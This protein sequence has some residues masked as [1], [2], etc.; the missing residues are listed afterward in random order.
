LPGGKVPGV[1]SG[2]VLPVFEFGLVGLG[3]VFVGPV[4]GFVAFGFVGFGFGVLMP[5]EPDPTTT[6]KAFPAMSGF[7]P[8]PAMN[9]LPAAEL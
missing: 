8:L 1:G 6:L 4:L 3:L 2:V 9:H 7:S 5:V